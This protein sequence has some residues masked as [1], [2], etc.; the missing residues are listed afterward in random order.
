M[1]RRSARGSAEGAEST[2]GLI[3]PAAASLGVAAIHGAF[4]VHGNSPRGPGSHFGQ[5]EFA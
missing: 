3:A 1:R 5:T 2:S 4:R